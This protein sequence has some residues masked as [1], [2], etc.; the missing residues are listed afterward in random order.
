MPAMY[1]RL[2][3][4]GATG[5]TNDLV[6]DWLAQGVGEV[7]VA[8]AD[9]QTTGR[10]RHGR[11]WQAPAGA[12]LLLTTGFRPI[13]LAAER[14]W[15]LGATVALAMA[16]AAEDAA[17]LPVGAIRLKWPNDLVIETSGPGALLVGDLTA[18]AARARLAAPL[19]LRKL[20]GVL[21]ESEGLGTGDPRVVVGIGTNADWAAADFPP[22]LATTMTSLREASAGRPIDRE[23]LLRAFLD[24]L[25]G[26][27]EALRAG[28]FDVADW[29][30]RQATTGRR[31]V[32]EPVDGAAP[33]PV[34]AV[35]VDG[36][37]GALLV[38]DGG[39]RGRDRH[40]LAGEVVR[41][42]LAPAG[43]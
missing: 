12:A 43:V 22:E 14:I 6:R 42:R 31:V 30:G 11:S 4:F 26:R 35:G 40:V 27:I 2:E 34:L 33:Q 23:A 5:S 3:R 15:R 17:G 10:G 29:A 24:R 18:D 36:A 20:A 37:T 39:D 19:E 9:E 25:E 13:W 28:Y 7:C 41:V 21:G 38:E 32:L 16:D 8:V 1:S